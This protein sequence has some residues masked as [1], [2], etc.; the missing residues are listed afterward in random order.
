MGKIKLPNGTLLEF[1]GQTGEVSDIYHTFDELYDHRIELFIALCK[2]LKKA[3]EINMATIN[4]TRYNVWRSKRHS[5]GE[6]AFGGTWFVLGIFKRSGW[7]ITY[8]LPIDKWG[9]TEFAETLHK[10]PEW[11]GPAPADVLKRLKSL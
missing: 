10:A 7:Q 11:D 8:H 4:S 5:D 2:S 3:D 1:E 6:L 9:E